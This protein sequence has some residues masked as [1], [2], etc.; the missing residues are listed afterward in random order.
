MRFSFFAAAATTLAALVIA[1]ATTERTP[2]PAVDDPG[3]L[4]AGEPDATEA[5]TRPYPMNQVCP[6]S[7]LTGDECGKCARERCCDSRQAILGDDAGDG[8]VGCTQAP[9]CNAGEDCLVDC[10]ARFPTKVQA[11]LDHFTCLRGHC[12][13]PCAPDRNACARCTDEQCMDETLACN[14]SRDCF[15][16]QSC[17]AACDGSQSC[18]EACFDKYPEGSPLANALAVCGLNRCASE[19]K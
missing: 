9:D 2:A 18:L 4:D 15:V 8:L 11:Y 5:S 1:C 12:V 6:P 17:G 14:L 13:E 3:E 7:D 16:L 19:C 10:F